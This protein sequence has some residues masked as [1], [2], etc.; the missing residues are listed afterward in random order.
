MT[1]FDY[2]RAEITIDFRNPYYFINQWH[3]KSER[4]RAFFIWLL[5]GW[6]SNTCD[7]WVDIGIR[8]I[9]IEI[10]YRNYL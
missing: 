8:F 3:L 2:G 7:V 10:N 4:A 6:C 5:W 1:I 9:G